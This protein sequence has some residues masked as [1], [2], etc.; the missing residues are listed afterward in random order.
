MAGKATQGQKNLFSEEIEFD[1]DLCPFGID[2]ERERI[3][4]ER[5]AEKEE[6]VVSRLRRNMS[7]IQAGHEARRAGR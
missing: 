3:N 1:P 2:A 5:E 6:T 7:A 4:L